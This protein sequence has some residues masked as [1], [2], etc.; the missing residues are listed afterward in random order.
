[1]A[2]YSSILA[3]KIPQ[4][5]EPGRL[6]FIG[7]Q[8]VKHDL[9]SEQQLTSS[10]YVCVLLKDQ[11]AWRTQKEKQQVP[12]PSLPPPFSVSFYLDHD[13]YS[14]LFSQNLKLPFVFLSVFTL[15]CFQ[16]FSHVNN[17]VEFSFPSG[18]ISHLSPNQ[19]ILLPP[20]EFSYHFL[21]FSSSSSLL[22]KDIKEVTVLSLKYLNMSLLP[23]SLVV[24][25]G[26]EVPVEVIFRNSNTLS[27]FIQHLGFW[28]RLHTF[29]RR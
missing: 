6:Q 11:L 18:T 4:T 16:V 27:H 17:S 13:V 12:R 21:L 29:P 5:E 28:E 7:L 24:Q 20:W 10:R 1:M 14:S 15:K 8:R 2:T 25:L 19:S 23:A 26:I 22:R 3:W 9:A